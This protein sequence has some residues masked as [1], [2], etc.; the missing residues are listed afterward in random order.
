MIEDNIDFYNIVKAFLSSKTT[1]KFDLAWSNRLKP[2][3][4]RLFDE[5]F[6]AVLLDLNLP[7]SK[8]L[9]SYKTIHLE[10]PDMPVVIFTSND[11]EE[12]AMEAIRMGAQ[13]YL[14]KGHADGDIISR[15]IR[16]SVERKSS[17]IQLRDSNIRLQ[18]LYDNVN[19]VLKYVEHIISP[20]VMSKLLSQPRELQGKPEKENIAILF[21]DIR[22]FTSISEKYPPDVTINLLNYLLG[23]MADTVIS[24]GGTLDKFLGDGLMAFFGA[25]RKTENNELRAV[26]AAYKMQAIAEIFNLQ[27]FKLFP[28]IAADDDIKIGVG[29]NA[30]S[31]MVGFIG[32]P[33]RWEYTAIGDCVNI[34]SR[35]ASEATG[36]EILVT[37]DVAEACGSEAEFGAWRV[38]MLKGKADVTEIAEVKYVKL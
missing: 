38:L 2:G 22:G 3:L 34:A 13:D 8:G 4:K 21:A 18:K 20:D 11:N 29:I 12:A 36:G 35:L 6:D 28:E 26:Q 14:I 32:S 31:A 37:S 15:A 10:H 9:E 23:Q 33:S 27:R 25:P 16:Y 30:G 19:Y 24:Q 1:I 17:D 7:D 5:N